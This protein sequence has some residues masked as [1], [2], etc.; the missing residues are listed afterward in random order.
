MPGKWVLDTKENK[1]QLIEQ[2]ACGVNKGVCLH[3]TT[4]FQS[5]L[6][7]ALVNSDPSFLPLSI[8]RIRLVESKSKVWTD[9]HKIHAQLANSLPTWQTPELPTWKLSS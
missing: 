3:A 1:C 9:L 8:R 7:Q 5:E 6:K 4:Q 2:N